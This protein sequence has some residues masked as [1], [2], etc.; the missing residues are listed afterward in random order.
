VLVMI[1]SE[2]DLY[3]AIGE[4]Q[5]DLRTLIAKEKTNSE[6]IERMEKTVERRTYAGAGLIVFIMSMTD[7]KQWSN[8]FSMIRGLF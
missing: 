4:I 2:Q 7:P 1:E 5:A 8:W 3:T 6:R